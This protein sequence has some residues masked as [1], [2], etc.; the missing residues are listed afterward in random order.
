M[1]NRTWEVMYFLRV[2]ASVFYEAVPAPFFV[3]KTG[4]T[5]TRTKTNHQDSHP[6]TLYDTNT[7]RLRR[8]RERERDGIIATKHQYHDCFKTSLETIHKKKKKKKIYKD[9]IKALHTRH[10]LETSHKA[11]GNDIH[12]T[13]RETETTAERETRQP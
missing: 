4:E 1:Q 12:K 8:E 13:R 11:S 3:S 10:V 7:S 9:M 6:A 2:L 5:G